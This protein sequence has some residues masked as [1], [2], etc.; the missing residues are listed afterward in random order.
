MKTKPETA[1]SDWIELVNEMSDS[2]KEQAEEFIRQEFGG[3]GNGYL[4]SRTYRIKTLPQLLA[5]VKANL[6]VWKVKRW[7]ANKWEIGAKNKDKQVVVEPLWQVKA[8]LSERTPQERGIIEVLRA[9][10]SKA[11]I[12]PAVKRPKSVTYS[13]RALEISIVDPHFGLECREPEADAPWDLELAAGAIAE[14]SET[15]IKLAGPFGPFSE[16]LLPIGNDWN[17]S[18][19]VFHRT[20]AGTPQPEAIS[21]HRAYRSSAGAAIELVERVRKIAPVRVVQIPGNHSRVA[22][23]TLGMLLDAYFR[24]CPDVT[25][26]ATSSPYKFWRYGKTLI[27]FEHGHSVKPIRLAALMANERPDDW[28]QTEYR[29]W[30]LADQHRKGSSKP[31]MLEEQGVSVEYLPALVAPN[32]WHRLKS[33]NHQKRGAVAFVYDFEAGPVARFQHNIS[34][35]THRPMLCSRQSSRSSRSR[36]SKTSPSR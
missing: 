5:E 19:D 12:I 35:Y 23:F 27:G 10:E 20:T 36:S 22:D 25:V 16:V 9:I 17:H 21:W 7:L 13:K 15:L 18:D 31:S 2:H 28:Q 29:E 11:P 4:E 32:E 33:Y 24:N 8:W 14:A 6:D 26:D 30:H 3:D 34:P 1:D